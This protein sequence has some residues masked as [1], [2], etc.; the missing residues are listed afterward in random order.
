MFLFK[1]QNQVAPG[2]YNKPIF[3]YNGGILQITVGF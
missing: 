3:G 2:N 1:K